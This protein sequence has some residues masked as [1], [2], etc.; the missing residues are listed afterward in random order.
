M[1]TTRRM[2]RPGTTSTA[3]AKRAGAYDVH[4][5]VATVQEWVRTLPEKTGRSLEQWLAL[6][7]K[8]GPASEAEQRAWLTAEH[9]LGTNSAW[10]IAARLA[11]KGAEDQDPEAYLQAAATWVDAMY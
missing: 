4:P 11:G 10:W 1:P 5:G 9:G 8:E 3:R 6:V 7:K 2:A